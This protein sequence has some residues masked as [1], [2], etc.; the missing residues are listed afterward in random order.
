LVHY[1]FGRSVVM[2]VVFHRFV[3]NTF[4]FVDNIT[5]FGR[6]QRQSSRRRV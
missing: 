4:Q 6:P 1:I 5:A 2:G 3:E